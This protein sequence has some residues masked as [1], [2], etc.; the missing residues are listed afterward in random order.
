MV[1]RAGALEVWLLI[2][3]G[4]VVISEAFHSGRRQLSEAS[5][6]AAEVFA[7]SGGSGGSRAHVFEGEGRSI[8]EVAVALASDVHQIHEMLFARQS[9][10]G[11]HGPQLA[12][13]ASEEAP[14]GALVRGGG[15]IVVAP[16]RSGSSNLT[17]LADQL[18]RELQQQATSEAGRG[19]SAGRLAVTR[20]AE[21]LLEGEPKKPAEEAK[22]KGKKDLTAEDPPIEPDSATLAVVAG[23]VV[24]CFLV[25][26]YCLWRSC[27]GRVEKYATSENAEVLGDD[28]AEV[29]VFEQDKSKSA[30]S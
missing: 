3:L 30:A 17:L 23:S 10:S 22:P 26:S 25:F 7:G 14:G 8:Q 13:L 12:P 21:S 4:G 2:W 19:L 6:S 28:L 27:C 5:A 15:A 1:C 18:R 11:H 24:G 9:S 20:Y 16:S 29:W